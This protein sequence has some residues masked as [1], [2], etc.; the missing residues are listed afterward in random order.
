M[1]ATKQLEAKDGE[2]VLLN[3]DEIMQ[4]IE[5]DGINNLVNVINEEI[6]SR[7]LSKEEIEQI[8]EIMNV[9]AL[10]GAKWKNVAD[11][12][13][14]ISI[15]AIAESHPEDVKKIVGVLLGI[16]GMFYPV[17]NSAQGLLT[18][19]PDK[20]FSALITIGGLSSPEYLIYKGVNIIAKKKLEKAKV[21]AECDTGMQVDRTTLIVVCKNKLLS[22]EIVKLIETEDDIDDQT[23]V[24]I[25]DGSVQ[26]ILWN[27]AAW[28]EFHVKLT[29]TEKILIIDEIKNTK[30]LATQQ[31]R[32]EKFG[33]RYGWDGNVARIE[34]NPKALKSTNDYKQ[35]L[36]SMSGMGISEKL[37]KNAKFKFD[38]ATAGKLAVFPPLLIADLLGEGK[39]VRQQQ[40]LFGLYN[41]YTQDMNEFLNQ[42][43]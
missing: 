13:K 3:V 41:F 10:E 36:S 32:F 17:A 23:I 24:G 6:G 21:Q 28:Q 29:G 26:T 20:L 18:K 31:I 34:A 38:W 12:L 30:M 22:N 14:Y 25:K 43:K 37:K 33:V 1:I 27:E 40:L 19:V 9:D 15:F 16:V 42:E 39:E 5:Q 4:S 7:K 8:R 11:V 35:F 2:S